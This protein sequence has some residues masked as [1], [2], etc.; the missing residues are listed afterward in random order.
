MMAKPDYVYV[1]YIE[2]TAEKLWGALT[3]PKMTAG[4]WFHEN[5]SDWKPGSRWE[6]RRL[7]DAASLDIVGKVVESN[8]PKKLVLTWARPEDESQEAKHSRVTFEL[9]QSHGSTKLTV[10]HDRLENDPEMLR[11]VSSG[12]PAVISSLKSFLET[13]R[14]LDAMRR[15]NEAA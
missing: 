4:Y 10:I 5:V 2:T 6:H 14:A 8:P 11:G 13:G 12:W 1:A 3:D 9:E 15:W 7:N